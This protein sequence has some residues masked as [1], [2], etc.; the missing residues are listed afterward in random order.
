MAPTPSWGPS[1]LR[2]G[3][4][5]AGAS[6]RSKCA[7]PRSW[8]G[9]TPSP[10]ATR[11]TR[12]RSISR[13]TAWWRTSR[14]ASRTRRRRWRSRT[15]ARRKGRND[16]RYVDRRLG[17]SH[18]E[19]LERLDQD[20]RYGKVAEPLLVRRHDEPGRLGRAAAGERV[21]V[22]SDVVVPVR[23]VLQITG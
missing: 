20:A 12:T 4:S 5:T 15:A 13:M 1:T 22:R 18:I 17:E 9:S 23:P 21:L 2:R 8:T 7:M 11:T 19:G 16:P 10:N 6:S 14:I 3:A